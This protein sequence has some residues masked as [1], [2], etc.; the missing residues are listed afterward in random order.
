MS[1][2]ERK[3]KGR[4]PEIS[5][6]APWVVMVLGIVVV[7]LNIVLPQHPPFT[8]PWYSDL[9]QIVVS[10]PSPPLEFA[11][12]EVKVYPELGGRITTVSKL[13]L[14]S[15]D[16][17]V[18]DFRF[19]YRMNSDESATVGLSIIPDSALTNL[20]AMH[21]NQ[22]LAP[23]LVHLTG[24]VD[25][26]PVME[27]RLL[28]TGFEISDDGK[29]EKVILSDQPAQWTWSIRPKERGKH[30]LAVVISIPVLVGSDEWATRSTYVVQRLETTIDVESSWLDRNE[31]LL[32]W[33]TALLT[34][35]TAVCGIWANF[36]L[37]RREE[38]LKALQAKVA[39]S[40][41]ENAHLLAEIERIK[42]IPKWQFWRK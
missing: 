7:L 40:D 39:S 1:D 29:A 22:H 8:G 15:V 5:D 27:A 31:K 28:G 4:L 41:V 23:P 9:P 21:P 37:K 38:D 33:I 24:T 32:P 42:A 18:A 11:M 35:C 30:S 34:F 19:P 3:A 6:L 17:G 13:S 10:T 26:Y 16:M 12:L 25:I 36:T 2:I 14:N 20:L